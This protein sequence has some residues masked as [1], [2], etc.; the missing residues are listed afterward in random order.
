[1]NGIN[2][3]SSSTTVNGDLVVQQAEELDPYYYVVLT[4]L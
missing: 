1:M 4:S 3:L 2:K